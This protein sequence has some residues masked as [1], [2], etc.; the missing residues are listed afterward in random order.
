MTA[1]RVAVTDPALDSLLSEVFP[2]K[3][4]DVTFTGTPAGVRPL[5]PGDQVEMAIE[6]LGR[7][8]HPVVGS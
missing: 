8:S 6:G 7:L 2:L 4:S 3:S 5:L 1:S